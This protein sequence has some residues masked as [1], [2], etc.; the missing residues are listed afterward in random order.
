MC[1]GFSGFLSKNGTVYFIEPDDRGD[2]SHHAVLARMPESLKKDGEL[3][4]FE[5]PDWTIKSFRWDYPGE[6]PNWADKNACGK[7]LRQVKPVWTE[8]DKVCNPA[9]TGYEKVCAQALA[10]YDKVR[11]QARAEYEKVVDPA[12]AEYKKVRDQALAEY[13][14][15]CAQALAEEY[16]KVRN[17][18]RTEYDKV[19]DQARKIMIEK[20]SK[21]DGY[22]K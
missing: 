4:P 9:R 14:K 17:P 10:E 13:N 11:D 6:V 16:N 2:I 5:F 22:C 12:W 7:L 18:A 1:N 8:Y 15:V 3:I 19:V 21:I 20:L